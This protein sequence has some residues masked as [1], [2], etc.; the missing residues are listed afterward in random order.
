MPVYEQV[1]DE[2]RSYPLFYVTEFILPGIFLI[3]TIVNFIKLSTYSLYDYY[4][5]NEEPTIIRGWLFI[6][7]VLFLITMT[8][9][10]IDCV[11]M[12]MRKI[13]LTSTRI[14][15]RNGITN[16]NGL[17]DVL[18]NVSEISVSHG[19]LGKVFGYGTIRIR[20]PYHKYRFKN[21]KD[22]DRFVNR[23]RNAVS[24]ANNTNQNS[25]QSP[26]K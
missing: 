25:S 4:R 2:T 26:Q 5:T 19:L 12:A 8:M 10:I 14:V 3:S 21:M 9:S 13:Q 24:A 23:V 18:V 15:G 6:F 22:P 17:N 11:G 16:M 7:L 1:I 20:T